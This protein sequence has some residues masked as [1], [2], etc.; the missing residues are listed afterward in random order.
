MSQANIVVKLK[1]EYSSKTIRMQDANKG[2]N[3]SLEE[4]QRQA[5]QYAQRLNALTSKQA[6]LQTAMAKAKNEA[7]AASKAFAASGEAADSDAL[8][9]ANKKYLELKQEMQGVSLAAKDTSKAMRELDVDN[10]KRSS[11]NAG[12]RSIVSQLGAAGATAMVGDLL[13]QAVGTFAGSALGDVGGN[14]ISSVLSSGATGAAIGSI[15]PGIGT[16][17]GAALGGLGGLIKGKMDEYAKEDDSYKS[18]VQDTYSA[19]TGERA[20][21]LQSG[22]GIAAKR[23]TDQISF[24]TLFGDAEVARGFLSDLKDMANVTPFLYDDLTGMSKTLKTFGYGVDEMIPAMMAVGDAGAALGMSTEDMNTVST[25]IG[26]M[27]STDKASLEFLNQ[28]TERGIDVIGWMAA[29]DDKSKGEVYE[30]ISKGKYSGTDVAQLVLDQL[31]INFGGAM[32]MQSETYGGLESTLQGMNDEMANAQGEGYNSRR[33]QGMVDQIAFLGGQTGQEMQEAYRMMG[34]YQAELENQ[35]EKLLRDAFNSVTSGALVGNW[36]TVSEEMK[37]KL[38]DLMADYDKAK[39]EG[40]GAEMGRVLSAAQAMAQAEYQNSEGYQIQMAADMKL[41]NDVQEAMAG[42]YEDYGYAMAQMFTKGYANG[43]QQLRGYGEQ[44][45]SYDEWSATAV[46]IMAP[47]EKPSGHA[48]GLNRV[49]YDNYPALLHQG[50]RVLTASQARRQD[51]SGTGSILITGNEFNVR[52]EADVGRVAA[53]IMDKIL[54]AQM[55]DGGVM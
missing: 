24:S 25:A 11:A 55:T 19:L 14:Y 31:T 1:D 53:E 30:G 27:R 17:I 45:L 2:F 18:S 15:I 50:E 8:T 46:D 26:R 20:Q 44:P 41:V 29:R 32:Q 22:S 5:Q 3:K 34:E 49:P 9:A 16:A 10:Q 47:A 12:G 48:Y 21:Q 52:E 51:R 23:E 37:A 6:E 38:T 39:L 33:K 13:S 43:R 42:R 35:Q 4:T 7:A 54:A 40:D 28:L 36:Q